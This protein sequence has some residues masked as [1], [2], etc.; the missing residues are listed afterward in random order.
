M[1]G[2]LFS[3]LNKSVQDGHAHQHLNGWMLHFCNFLRQTLLL[4]I[5]YAQPRVNIRNLIQCHVGR[6]L[7][8]P[9]FDIRYIVL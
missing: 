7:I 8:S 5:E 2:L 9:Y 6:G 4:L 3:L 1:I